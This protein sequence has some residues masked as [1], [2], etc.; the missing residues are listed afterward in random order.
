MIRQECPKR[1]LFWV[2]F[3]DRMHQSW[4]FWH[5]FLRPGFYHC[6]LMT[7]CLTGSVMVHPLRNTWALEHSLKEP[8]EIAQELVEHPEHR[9]R[10]LVIDRSTRFAYSLRG[11][12]TC[13]SVVKAALGLRGLSLTPYQL[14]Q[15]LLRLGA[16]EVG[17]G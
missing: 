10:V 14:Y 2:V 4:N 1:R 15:Q 16:V 17:E 12:I 11:V 5:V 13:V 6:W 3:E 9:Y 7:Q 8:H